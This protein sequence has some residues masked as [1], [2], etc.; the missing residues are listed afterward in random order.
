MRMFDNYI[1]YRSQ[2]TNDKEILSL[3][4]SKTK[5]TLQ[6]TNK[7]SKN[8]GHEIFSNNEDNEVLD[9]LVD[10]ND[11]SVE[12]MV[13]QSDSNSITHFD[14]AVH[15]VVCTFY[16]EG[17]IYFTTNQIVQKLIGTDTKTKAS[18]TL[19]DK[20]NQSILKMRKTDITINHSNQFDKWNKHEEYEDS[21]TEISLRYMLN[22]NV[23]VT[24]KMNGNETTA[25][26]VNEIPP[27]LEYSNIY[28]Q[29][30][31]LSDELIDTSGYLTHNNETIAIKHYLNNRIQEMKG[32]RK[33]RKVNNSKEI[34]YETMY[35]ALNK[36][37][38]MNNNARKQRQRLINHVENILRA[39]KEN[40]YI[41]DYNLT[42][43]SKDT[44][45]N[46]K[47]VIGKIKDSEGYN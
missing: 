2:G 45:K 36:P 25:F 19:L 6:L 7:V 46:G 32:M 18:K 24:V 15:E 4:Y 38:L 22:V 43:K 8:I 1:E 28:K 26:K 35:K 44:T 3:K 5:N 42:H 37:Q 10:N 33:G 30:V 23:D 16:N 20:I 31:S 47:I 12:L 21:D 13:N 27:L 40:G 17:Q 9:V 14:K 11:T 41:S 29:L 34:S 39:Y